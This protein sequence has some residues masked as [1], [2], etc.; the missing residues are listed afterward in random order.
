MIIGLFFFST[1]FTFDLS[2]TVHAN[3]FVVENKLLT[4]RVMMI[5][6]GD[7]TDKTETIFLMTIFVV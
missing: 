6:M 2:L 7:N 3:P 4:R 5:K 1:I